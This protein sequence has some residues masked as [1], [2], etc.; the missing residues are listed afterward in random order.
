M[1]KRTHTHT[2]FEISSSRVHDF[3]LVVEA[4]FGPWTKIGPLTFFF[5]FPFFSSSSQN[6][7]LS[8]SLSLC[9]LLS[10]HKKKHAPSR[11]RESVESLLLAL[12][13]SSRAFFL[14][15]ICRD[16]VCIFFYRKN[17]TKEQKPSDRRE[18][19]K[20]GGEVLEE[21]FFGSGWGG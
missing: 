6:T 1:K 8:L 10:R 3:T 7:P 15:F 4:F 20:G 13:F 12:P 18:R 16:I 19:K 21:F 11:G 14:F 2:Y 17:K 5:S 9:F